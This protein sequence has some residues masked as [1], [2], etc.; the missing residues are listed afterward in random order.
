MKANAVV[1]LLG[2][3]LRA[4]KDERIDDIEVEGYE[5]ILTTDDGKSLQTW[6]IS[7]HGIDETD[8]PEER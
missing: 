3:I 5:I 4:S 2:D 1:A 6:I 8:P 7:K